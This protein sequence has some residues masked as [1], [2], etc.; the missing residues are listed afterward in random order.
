MSFILNS[1]LGIQSSHLYTLL[2]SNLLISLPFLLLGILVSSILLVFVDGHQ[3]AAKFP[4]S[5]ILGVIMGSSL[6]LLL[7][8]GQYG[9][10]P[11][12]RRLLL[13]GAPIPVC[14]SFLIASPTINLF[15]LKNSWQLLGDHPRLLF[16]RIFGAW[17]IGIMIGLV[18][19]TYSDKYLLREKTS[20]SLTNHSSLVRSGTV[21]SSLE[22]SQPLHRAGNL[23]YEYQD[24]SGMSRSL[25]QKLSLFCNNLIQEF[26]ELGSILLIGVALA[27]V[28]QFFLPQT[29]LIQWTETP[30]NQIII[31]ILFGFFLSLNSLSSPYF[32]TP[33]LTS[34]L[35]G[36]HLVFLLFNS[37]LN[38]PS[39]IL[40]FT[41]LRLKLATYIIILTAELIFI[42]GLILNFYV[43]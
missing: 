36:S 20:S 40:L 37:L 7:P 9:T 35:S 24:S 5:R 29:Q 41:I 26:L 25:G 15:V 21:I 42:F 1:S 27:T 6:G 12:V 32:L 43:S 38:L 11:V 30:L 8:V 18:F 22:T 23:I 16:L 14:I 39:L 2:I 33:F 13:Q 17:L 4:R 31:M 28:C 34:F 19:S 10:L 3:L